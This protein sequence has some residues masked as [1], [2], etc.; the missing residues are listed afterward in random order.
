MVDKEPA[1]LSVKRLSGPQEMSA[2]RERLAETPAGDGAV[3]D[4]DLTREL[5]LSPITVGERCAEVLS[6]GEFVHFS[7][8]Q[9]SMKK[10]FM[11]SSAQKSFVQDFVMDATN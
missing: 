10:N 2:L 1:W 4:V 9:N 3:R 7:C 8:V 6:K 5:F 11:S